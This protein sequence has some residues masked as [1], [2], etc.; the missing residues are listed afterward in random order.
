MVIIW[1]FFVWKNSVPRTW[2]QIHT[3]LEE[4]AVSILQ[5]APSIPKI[6]LGPTGN[7]P[8]WVKP[9]GTWGM[10]WDAFMVS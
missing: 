2:G 6:C 9:R 1:Q 3:S 7:G 10:L 5:P 4:L 8:V